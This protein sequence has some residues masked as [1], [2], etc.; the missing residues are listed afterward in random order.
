MEYVAGV[1]WLVGSEDIRLRRWCHFA[2]G[3]YLWFVLMLCAV[4]VRSEVSTRWQQCTA[5]HVRCPRSTWQRVYLPAA[6]SIQKAA[7]HRPE[8]SPRWLHRPVSSTVLS[9]SRRYTQKWPGPADI[10]RVCC[11]RQK[12]DVSRI[13]HWV[14]TTVDWCT[15]V[16]TGYFQFVTVTPR[17]ICD[18]IF[19][20]YE[21]WNIYM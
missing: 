5:V 20:R 12:P 2:G 17:Y 4:L 8:L 9:L 6:D 11:I 16:I 15:G 21:C 14:R 7:L 1:D 10:S 19:F 3:L 13:S 18:A